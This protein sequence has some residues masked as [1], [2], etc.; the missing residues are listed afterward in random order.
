MLRGSRSR[1]SIRRTSLSSRM[2]SASTFLIGG[3]CSVAVVSPSSA[4]VRRPNDH[5]DL[6]EATASPTVAGARSPSP[7]TKACRSATVA[8]PSGLPS[9]STQPPALVPVARPGARRR[10]PGRPR[11]D[12]LPVRLRPRRRG[13][14]PRGGWF[15]R[16]RVRGGGGASSG[17]FRRG[18]TGLFPRR[19]RPFPASGAGRRITSGLVLR[20]ACPEHAR[21]FA[22]PSRDVVGIG[23]GRG[24]LRPGSGPRASRR[25]CIGVGSPE[26]KRPLSLAASGPSLGRKRPRRACARRRPHPYARS[27]SAQT[28]GRA[29]GWVLA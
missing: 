13:E 18:G 4:P 2:R 20:P 14:G 29:H 1:S 8:S 3:A 7:A 28:P 27:M 6:I 25:R 12:Q 11:L 5:S 15:G 21:A 17:R 23:H 24:F 9:W 10:L 22:R 26:R 19:S 16:R